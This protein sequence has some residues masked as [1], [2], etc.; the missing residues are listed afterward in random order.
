MWK[1]ELGIKD[2]NPKSVEENVVRPLVFL[3][4]EDL[5]GQ[6][7]NRPRDEVLLENAMGVK[8]AFGHRG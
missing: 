2:K 5:V 3:C 8:E 1:Y 4:V 6:D 7:D